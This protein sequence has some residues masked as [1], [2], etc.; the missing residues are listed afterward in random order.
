[1]EHAAS[2]YNPTVGVPVRHGNAQGEV[3]L[4]F[5]FQPFVDVAASAE[6]AFFAEERRVVDGEEHAHRRFVDGDGG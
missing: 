3:L 6:L 5:F 4:Q 2:G 1:M